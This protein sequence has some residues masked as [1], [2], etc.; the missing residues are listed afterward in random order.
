MAASMFDR[1]SR[2]IAARAR[3]PL[4]V[5]LLLASALFLWIFTAFE[6]APG[7][8][9]HGAAGDAPGFLD[10]RWHY[11]AA[12]ARQAMH[13]YGAAG[14]AEYRR[15]LAVDAFFPFV[16]GLAFALL[17]S[18]LARALF[19]EASPWLRLNLLPLATIVADCVE[20]ACLLWMLAG[21]PDF[22]D[23]AG[24]LGGYAT[25]LKHLTLLGVLLSL[26]GGGI[27]LWASRRARPAP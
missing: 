9:D 16:Y 6:L 7:A 13:D 12:E 21:H 19:G 1:I 2:A 20:N 25:T 4:I 22:G 3:F 8:A 11:T 5:A 14:R 23:V 27:A 26:A 10:L 18:R 24:T 15:F 17:L